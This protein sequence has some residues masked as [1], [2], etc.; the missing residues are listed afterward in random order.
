MTSVTLSI[1]GMTCGGCAD[2]LL[3]LFNQEA[4]V[5]AASVSHENAKADV[6]FDP[7][8]VSKQRLSEIVEKAGFLVTT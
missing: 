3:R 2:S 8:Q 7:D 6:D 1:S 5:V 4:G